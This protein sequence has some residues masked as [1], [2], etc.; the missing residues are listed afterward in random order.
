MNEKTPQS[1]L[2]SYLTCPWCPAQAYLTRGGQINKTN[3][4]DLGLRQYICPANHKFLV[5]QRYDDG[6]SGVR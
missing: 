2:P 1:I 3:F 4:R 5:E 6:S